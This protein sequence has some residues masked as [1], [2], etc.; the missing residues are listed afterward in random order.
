MHHTILTLQYLLSTLLSTINTPHTTTGTV[1]G[2][3]TVTD[4]DEAPK[5]DLQSPSSIV[6]MMGNG[7]ESKH[8]VKYLPKGFGMLI[9]SPKVNSMNPMIIDTNARGNHSS[10]PGTPQVPGRHGPVPK[11]SNVGPE[12]M[13]SGIMEC[14]C[15][16][17]FPK[18]IAS[19]TTKDSGTCAGTT[20]M[21]S[22]EQCF[23]AAVSLGLLAKTN[24]TVHS[25]TSPPGCFASAISGGF[26][27]SV[28]TYEMR[29]DLWVLLTG[30]QCSQ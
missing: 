6:L 15:T 12:A 18:T 7:A 28:D 25:D 13:Y 29:Y 24:V 17:A 30:S 2:Y 10:V 26:E 4:E 1:E 22:T 23:G 20:L 9:G 5:V 21:S 3:A 11:A 27:V 8:S 16:D 19:A 14:P